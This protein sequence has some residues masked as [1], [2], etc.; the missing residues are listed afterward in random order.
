MMKNSKQ[1]YNR[2]NKSSYKLKTNRPTNL[3]RQIQNKSSY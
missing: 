3:I 1:I 2:Q